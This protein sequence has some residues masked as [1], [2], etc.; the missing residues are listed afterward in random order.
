MEW[1]EF[2]VYWL[3]PD[4]NIVHLTT[5]GQVLKVIFANIIELNSY[6]TY[7]KQS[8]P[9]LEPLPLQP[10]LHLLYIVWLVLSRPIH[11][12][13]TRWLYYPTFELKDKICVWLNK[14]VNAFLHYGSYGFRCSTNWA[15][16]ILGHDTCLEYW[17]LL[18][19]NSL[20]WEGNYTWPRRVI[21]SGEVG[22]QE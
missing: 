1:V 16:H 3:K 10:L 6:C 9:S 21:L 4:F 5:S 17:T 12:I 13:E 2:F 18:S 7:G 14:M 19:C 11:P 8:N 15:T 20:L 22:G